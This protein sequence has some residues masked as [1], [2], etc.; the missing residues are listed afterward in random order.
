MNEYILHIPWYSYKDKFNYYEKLLLNNQDF[1]DDKFFG[2]IKSL[3]IEAS[4]NLGVNIKNIVSGFDS[5]G[6]FFYF[7]SPHYS[8]FES[9]K[10]ISSSIDIHLGEFSKN[11]FSKLGMDYIET[12]TGLGSCSLITKNQGS[13]LEFR[14][15]GDDFE[16]L[17]HNVDIFFIDEYFDKVLGLKKIPFN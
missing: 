16:C 8:D 7:E 4:Y 13:Y 10:E 6:L 12:G 9:F 11:L 17:K 5:D 2:V 3:F 1:Y 14:N 15:I